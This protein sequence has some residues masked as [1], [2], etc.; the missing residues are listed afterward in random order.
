MPARGV[1]ARPA[2]FSLE[3]LLLLLDE[4]VG[5]EALAVVP[6]AIAELM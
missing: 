3:L 2:A 6:V 4:L 5:M 1:P